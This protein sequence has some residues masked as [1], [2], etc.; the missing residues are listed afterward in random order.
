MPATN[1][2]GPEFRAVIDHAAMLAQ[3]VEGA[4]D[5]EKALQELQYADDMGCFTDPTMWRDNYAD[6]QKIKALLRALIP[7]KKAAE[8]FLEQAREAQS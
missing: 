3:L 8:V 2:T 1:M 7:F 5:Y 6:R 4:M